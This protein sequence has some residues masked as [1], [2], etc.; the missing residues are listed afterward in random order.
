MTE[1]RRLTVF[2]LQEWIV[3]EEDDEDFPEMCSRPGFLAMWNRLREVA[4]L[5]PIDNRTLLLRARDEL[6]VLADE[7]P[8]N[9]EVRES[10]VDAEAA[11]LQWDKANAGTRGVGAALVDG[12]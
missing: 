11:L 3:E 8:Q 1:K 6:R 2:A 4:R 10:L 12:E 5:E 7:T 9:W